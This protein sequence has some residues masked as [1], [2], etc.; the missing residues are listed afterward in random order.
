MSA[1]ADRAADLRTEADALDSLAD[2]E[3]DLLAAKDAYNSAPT[4]ENRAARQ[5]AA[6][7]L[8]RARAETRTEGVTVG[9]DAF[10][11]QEG[12]A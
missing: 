7:A 11:E 2:L 8:R 12:P 5:A 9:G 4:E 6:E 10:I 3:A 1:S